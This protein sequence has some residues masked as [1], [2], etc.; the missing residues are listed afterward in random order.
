MKLNLSDCFPIG[1]DG[2]RTPLPKQLDFLNQ[3][4]DK[5][6]P[7]FIAYVGGVGSGK[8]LIGC[9]TM[10][11]QAVMYGGEYLIGRQFMPELKVTTY[12]TFL[13]LCPPELIIEHRIADATLVLKSATGK[14]AVIMFRGLEDPDKFRSLNLSGFYVDEA[15][16][17]SEEAFLLLQGRLR[18]QMGL[19]KGIVTTN[20]K[21]HDWI[22]HYWVKQDFFKLEEAKQKYYLVKAP[23]TENIHLP[24]GYVENLLN[25]YSEERIKREIMGSFDAFEGQVYSE[26]RRDVH[27]IKPFEIP[28]D[29][30]RLIGIDHGYR[31]PSAWIWAAVGPDAE[32]YVYR[33][34]Y[35][36]EWLISE[37]VNGNHIEGKVG[38]LERMY[39]EKIEAAAIDPSVRNRS[40]VKGESVLD[41]YMQYLP[42][43]FPLV[44][45]NNDKTLGINRLKRYFKIDTKI[46]K[47]MLYIFNN[48]TSLIDEIVKYRYQEL[49]P[50]AQGRKAEKEE[51]Y[52]V[53]DHALD[54]LRYLIMLRPE[55][56]V[57][58]EEET[59]KYKDRTES[60][61][62]LMKEIES[63]KKPKSVGIDL[64]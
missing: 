31:N 64:I 8:T 60:E 56:F 13:D 38:A 41:E 28:K 4:L 55:P 18:N 19:R 52:K 61:R 51:A 48:C 37:I 42:R 6:G 26:F 47:P 32:V 7:K 25:T 43:E 34:F 12:K 3:T 16:Q 33:E 2:R 27:V 20:P 57:V 63:L 53:D 9:I 49:N 17:I 59:K 35:E 44:M 11:S 50:R 21:G 54:A 22:Y 45:A 10:L 14:P 46:H 15:N 30:P 5:N 39:G 1:A 58:K 40:G 23:S 62:R 36:K 29:W 24:E